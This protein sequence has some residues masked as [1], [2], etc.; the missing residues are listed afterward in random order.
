MK[1]NRRQLA[2]RRGDGRWPERIKAVLGVRTQVEMARALGVQ[3]SSISDAVRRGVCPPDWLLEMLETRGASPAWV[4]TGA[5]PQWLAPSTDG[6]R[7]D[8]PV[9]AQAWAGM[10]TE[11]LMR[12]LGRRM[13]GYTICLIPTPDVQEGEPLGLRVERPGAAAQPH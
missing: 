9:P 2:R 10:E 7:P 6:K 3:Q 5:G 8:L 4:L 12:E 11:D 13:A 1:T